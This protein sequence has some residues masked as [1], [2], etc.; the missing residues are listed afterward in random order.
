MSYTFP[1]TIMILGVYLCVEKLVFEMTS[2]M[3]ILISESVV[4]SI[5]PVQDIQHCNTLSQAV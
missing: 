1:H 5:S 3:N 2:F 4:C